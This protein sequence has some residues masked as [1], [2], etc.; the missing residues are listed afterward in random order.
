MRRSWYRGRRDSLMLLSHGWIAKSLMFLNRLMLRGYLFVSLFRR[1]VTL[2][3]RAAVFDAEGRVFLVKHSYMP[4][5]Y[6]PGG[7]VDRGETMRQALERELME[8]AGIRLTGPAM[9]F[10]LYLNR[11]AR[12]ATMSP[13]MSA[14][15]G[16]GRRRPRYPTWKSSTV[17]STR[18]TPCRKASPPARAGGLPRSPG[19]RRHRPSGSQA[20]RSRSRPCGEV[21]SICGPT[22][23]M[24]RGLIERWLRK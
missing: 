15:T 12:H 22:G 24:P 20:V 18:P 16:P 23:T 8:E 10:G 9:L 3:V 14:V 11:H 5:W 19:P 1:G 7:G 17:A 2:G 4:G 21:R 6:L 13:S